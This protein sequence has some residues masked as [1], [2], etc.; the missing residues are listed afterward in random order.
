MYSTTTTKYSTTATTQYSTTTTLYSTTT[1]LYG[2]TTTYNSIIAYNSTVKNLAN[3]TVDSG[4]IANTDNTVVLVA[5][6]SG[7]VIALIVFLVGMIII[8]TSLICVK[9]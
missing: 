4:D 3:S 7:G 9:S 6:I 1:T 5:G 8:V 2:S